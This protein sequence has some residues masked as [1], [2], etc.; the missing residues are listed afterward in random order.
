MSTGPPKTVRDSLPHRTDAAAIADSDHGQTFWRDAGHLD[1]LLPT[2]PDTAVLADSEF[3]A[4]ADNLPVLCWIA[5]GDGYIVWYNRRWHDYCGTTP[6]QMQGWGW[7]SVHDPAQVDAVTE[8][9]Q[10]SIVSGKPFEMVFPL[11]GAD[12]RFRSFLTRIAPI[13]DASGAIVRWFGVNIEIDAQLHAEAALSDSQARYHVLTQAMPQMVWSTLP[14]GF[15]D[16][17]N[18]QWYKFTGVP[19]GSTDGEGWAGM[20]HP[21]DQERAR[22]IWQHSLETGE[23]YEVEYRLRHHSGAYRW[24]LGRALPVRDASGSIVR[25]IGTCTDIHDAKLAAEQN[26][27]LTRELAHR[28]KNIFAVITG[29][30]GLSARDEPEAKG[31]AARLTDRIL[32]LGRAHEFARPH[33][34]ESRPSFD[35][36]TLSAMLT[37]LMDPYQLPNRQRIVIAGSDLPVDDQAATPIAL[38]FHEL[39]TNAAKYGALSR[40]DGQV[41]IDIA[42]SDKSVTI[43]WSE[44]GGPAVTAPPVRT[45]FGSRLTELSVR[46]QLG[47][48]IDREW[49]P[50]GL[51]VTLNLRSDRLLRTAHDY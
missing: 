27:I 44:K 10:Q 6:E 31:F 37:D 17:Y 24:T 39:A 15:H 49:R 34:D 47:G 46:Q 13:V 50:D 2:L 4:L 35:R 12:G 14:D 20:F 16:F 36:T 8:R 5:R 18:D 41:T 7:K 28:I 3:H 30:I 40:D 11:K 21:D 23:P 22:P 1:V 32:A 42:L 33:S 51:L 9:W 48:Q 38:V 26:E 43:R 45:G 19:I 25:W 29:L